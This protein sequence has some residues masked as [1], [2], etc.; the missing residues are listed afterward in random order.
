M[1]GLSRPIV[2]VSFPDGLC[3]TC[4]WYVGYRDSSRDGLCKYNPP[5]VEAQGK[6]LWPVVVTDKDFCSK[7]SWYENENVED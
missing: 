2:D 5:S 3:G 6:A 1:S 7:Y 4:H